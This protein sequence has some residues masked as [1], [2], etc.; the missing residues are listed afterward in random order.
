MK[1]YK[2]PLVLTDQQS[3]PMPAGADILSAGLGANGQLCVWAMVNPNS[4]LRP[5]HLWI[6]G[7]GNP[8]PEV[9]LRFIGSVTI[10]PFVWHVFEELR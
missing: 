9:P 4:G 8:L 1:I 2:Y 5:R 10:A 7:T 3:H 6:V